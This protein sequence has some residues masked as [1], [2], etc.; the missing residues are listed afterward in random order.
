[1]LPTD[2]STLVI[3]GES[4]K[5]VHTQHTHIHT[6]MDA[7]T[8]THTGRRRGDEEGGRVEGGREGEVIISHYLLLE[9]MFLT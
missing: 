5:L 4:G 7:H 3:E 1:M 2:S 9:G 6:H 8:H